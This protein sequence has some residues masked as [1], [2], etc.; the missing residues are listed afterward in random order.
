M[1]AK[2]NVSEEGAININNH[3]LAKLKAEKGGRTTYGERERRDNQR[4]G[5]AQ[6]IAK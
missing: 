1:S 4:N 3:H 5:G 6:R 2:L